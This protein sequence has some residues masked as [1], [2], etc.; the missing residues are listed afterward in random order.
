M[1]IG[2]LQPLNAFIRPHP[3]PRTMLR[4][5]W[6]FVHKNLGRAA[7]LGGLVNVAGG[8]FLDVTKSLPVFDQTVFL[9]LW[10]NMLIFTPLVLRNFLARK[11]MG[12]GANVSDADSK[13]IEAGMGMDGMYPTVAREGTERFHREA[14]AKL[15][16]PADNVVL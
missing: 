1:L 6:E 2:V 7:V 13:A 5:V 14:G 3:K 12:T 15:A 10:C 8:I 9:V 16:T 4:E 11:Q